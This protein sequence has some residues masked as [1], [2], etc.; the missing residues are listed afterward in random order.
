[1]AYNKRSILLFPQLDT[2]ANTYDYITKR[3]FN[4]RNQV[5][6]EPEASSAMN[7]SLAS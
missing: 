7:S 4:K 3:E 1:M 5:M 6:I 2:I